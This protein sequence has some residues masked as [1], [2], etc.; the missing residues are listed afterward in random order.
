MSGP[1]RVVL[2]SDGSP[3]LRG[4]TMARLIV[5]DEPA[6]LL[7]DDLNAAYAAGLEAR[8][9][10][11]AEIRGLERA[12]AVALA[13]RDSKML[14]DNSFDKGVRSGADLIHKHIQAQ[15]DKARALTPAEDREYQIAVE[16]LMKE[17]G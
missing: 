11:E 6:R 10:R 5:A 7:I 13:C 1:Y 14:G 12:K 3:I 16:K 8:G 17:P 4:P 9:G 2:L 15:I